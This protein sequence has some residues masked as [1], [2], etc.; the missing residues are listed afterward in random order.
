[1]VRAVRRFL[2]ADQAQVAATAG[3]DGGGFVCELEGE[4]KTLYRA[5]SARPGH[6]LGV[7][8]AAALN[9]S[10]STSHL[11]LRLR[12]LCCHPRLVKETRKPPA[13]KIEA[14]IETLEPLMEEGQKVLSFTVRRLLAIRHRSKEA[15]LAPLVSGGDTEN[16]ATWSRISSG[17]RRGVF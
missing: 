3:P 14:L 16:V 6:A 9:K 15:P 17:G 13:R 8:T 1:L 7:K 10:G 11:L 5:E 12:Q 4:Q 2:S